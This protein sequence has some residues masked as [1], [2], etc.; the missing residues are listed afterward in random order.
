MLALLS[1]SVM[2][3]G[4]GGGGCS[5]NCIDGG[6]AVQVETAQLSV[7]QIGHIDGDADRDLSPA[8]GTPGSLTIN[9][10]VGGKGARTFTGFDTITIGR[11]GGDGQK[12]F[13]N[14]KKVV[15]QGDYDGN[16]NTQFQGVAS[17]Q[18][19]NFK[20]SG[21]IQY[22]G[23]SGVPSVNSQSGSGSITKSN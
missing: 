6:N 3:G 16:G 14:C 10:F 9:D 17:I 11:V 12:K 13:V 7:S 8:P 21:N 15:I 20:A 4:G 18:I 23:A 2:C 22:D 1:A 19:G 5:P